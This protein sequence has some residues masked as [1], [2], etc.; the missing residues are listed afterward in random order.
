MLINFEVS[1]G[2][3]NKKNMERN[4]RNVR[5]YFHIHIDLEGRASLA[6]GL[7][8]RQKVQANVSPQQRSTL[9]FT[10]D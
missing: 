7:N 4:S 10:T 5:V 2:L 9:Q 3:K 8:I 6:F 1:N